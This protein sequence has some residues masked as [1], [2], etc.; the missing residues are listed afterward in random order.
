MLKPV[1][2][3]LLALAACDLGTSR[4]TAAPSGITSVTGGAMPDDNG[5]RTFRLR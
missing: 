5:G 1:L 3:L 4:P 2:L